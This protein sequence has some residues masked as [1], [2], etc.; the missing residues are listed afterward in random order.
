MGSDSHEP[1]FENN[2]NGQIDSQDSE[3]PRSGEGA[4]SALATMKKQLKHL[5]REAGAT[6]ADDSG[7][8]GP[9]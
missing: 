6:A 9:A 4:A 7:P 5:R 3:Q 1:K 8:G 2:D